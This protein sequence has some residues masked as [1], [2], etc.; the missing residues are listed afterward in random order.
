MRHSMSHSLILCLGARSVAQEGSHLCSQRAKQD[1]CRITN[2]VDTSASVTS[3]PKKTC[4]ALDATVEIHE[5]FTADG[6]F[7]GL[8]HPPDRT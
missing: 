2:P 1:H 8:G 7:G 5:S 3:C 4:T 6:A